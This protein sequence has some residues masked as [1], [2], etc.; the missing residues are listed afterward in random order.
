MEP[1]WGHRWSPSRIRGRPRHVEQ[2]RFA[3]AAEPGPRQE[4]RRA[5][6]PGH[7]SIP[8]RTLATSGPPQSL[9]AVMVRGARSAVTSMSSP[10]ESSCAPLAIPSPRP[11]AS[12]PLPQRCCWSSPGAAVMLTPMRTRLPL[13]GPGVLRPTTAASRRPT[14]PR[15]RRPRTLRRRPG[16]SPPRIRSRRSPPRRPWTSC[17]RPRS[18]CPRDARTS[19]GATAH[20]A[21]WTTQ[22]RPPSSRTGCSRQELRRRRSPW[23]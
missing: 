13:P 7:L 21:G 14:T 11:A 6:G 4:P 1:P 2:I 17:T 9:T 20:G 23:R 5:E 22:P 18:C 15:R 3:E 16:Q 10:Q 8:G 12:P 19:S